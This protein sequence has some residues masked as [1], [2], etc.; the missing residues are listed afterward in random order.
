MFLQIECLIKKYK[1]GNDFID[2]INNGFSEK[3]ASK[4]ELQRLFE[5]QTQVDGKKDPIGLIEELKN[6]INSFD[7]DGTVVKD[8]SLQIF[9]YKNQIPLKQV[10]ALY[11]I[12]KITS[13]TNRS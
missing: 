12:N 5:Q 3:I 1:N 2:F 10:F 6:I 8:K 9:K 4:Q 7:I 13:I 11:G